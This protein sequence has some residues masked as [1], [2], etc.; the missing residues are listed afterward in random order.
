MLEIP[1]LIIVHDSAL[2]LGVTC[3]YVRADEIA[4]SLVLDNRTLELFA[5]FVF[6]DEWWNECFVDLGNIFI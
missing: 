5:C 3:K 4:V 2:L 1:V 6:F